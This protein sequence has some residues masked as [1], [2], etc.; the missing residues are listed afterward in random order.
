MLRKCPKHSLVLDLAN[1]DPAHAYWKCRKC[2]YKEF[3]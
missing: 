1:H 2:D 3:D